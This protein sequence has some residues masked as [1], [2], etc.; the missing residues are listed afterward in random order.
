MQQQIIV[1][2]ELF[3]SF[4]LGFQPHKVHSMLVH[5]LDPR[6]KGL[7][8]VIDFVDK[9]QTLQITGTYDKQVL[10]LLLVCAYKVLNLSDTCERAL[11]NFIS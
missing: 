6:Y 11:N 5:M 4:M 2:L 8:L 1:I 9:E 10:F 7:R 3:L